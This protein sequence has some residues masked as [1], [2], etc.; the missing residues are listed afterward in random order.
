MSPKCSQEEGG[1][2]IRNFADATSF[3]YG[4]LWISQLLRSRDRNT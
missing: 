3:K 2:K 1:P 4:Q